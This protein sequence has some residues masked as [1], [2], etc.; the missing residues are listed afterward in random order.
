MR[1]I[2]EGSYSSDDEDK[3]SSMLSKAIVIA[4]VS[5]KAHGK[6]PLSHVS[7]L[8]PHEVEHLEKALVEAG[9]TEK[10]FD[11]SG[12]EPGG[13]SASVSIYI[14]KWSYP[15]CFDPDRGFYDC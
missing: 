5:L 10:E 6:M 4:N 3:A 9:L 11:V 7:N 1:T 8:E 2:A 14:N 15:F 12:G 13:P